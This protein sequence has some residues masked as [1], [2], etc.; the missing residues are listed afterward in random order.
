MK[1]LFGA[2]VLAAMTASVPD[3]AAAPAPAPTVLPE[4]GRVRSTHICSILHDRI[5]PAIEHLANVDKQLQTGKLSFLSMAHNQVAGVRP[6]LQL[7][8]VHVEFAVKAMLDELA[9]MHDLL[10]NP[11]EFPTSPQ[12]EDG[13][14]AANL[15]AKL[16]EVDAQH[17]MAINV[18]NGTIETDQLGQMQHEG[19]SYMMSA[20]GALPGEGVT[21]TSAV[22][23]EPTSYI[24]YAGLPKPPD[25][26]I[27]PRS[28]EARDLGADTL[29]GKLAGALYDRQF[30]IVQLETS[31]TAAVVVLAKS[32]PSADKAPIAAP[33]VK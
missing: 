14:T 27:D 26:L 15:K 17:Q 11:N 29:F 20:I 24:G 28:I 2:F 13:K 8:E 23:I 12:T 9:K 18:M 4:I 1:E 22:A 33:S 16:E 30:H 21:A 3:G 6:A 5:A 32:C 10:S 7:D 19:M 25:L 31:L